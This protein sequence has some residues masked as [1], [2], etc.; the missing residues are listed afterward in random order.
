LTLKTPVVTRRDWR[1]W[2]HENRM[3]FG[4]D[5]FFDRM[6]DPAEFPA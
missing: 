1:P 4:F 3:F 5:E 2:K 6:F